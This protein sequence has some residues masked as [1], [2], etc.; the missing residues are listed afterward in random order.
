[1]QFPRESRP[2]RI[3]ERFRGEDLCLRV[4]PGSL[5]RRSLARLARVRV[6]VRHV[7]GGRTVTAAAPRGRLDISE[8][9]AFLVPDLVSRSGGGPRIADR[10]QS[11]AAVI[12]A[13]PRTGDLRPVVVKQ[14]PA[15]VPR[16]VLIDLEMG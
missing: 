14:P 16:V 4:V 2:V 12:E 3:T 6:V 11:A 5:T 10:P 8:F 1:V 13:L 7:I 9:A 15:P